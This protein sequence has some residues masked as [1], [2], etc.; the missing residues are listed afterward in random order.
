MAHI[1]SAD[2]IRFPMSAFPTPNLPF[3]ALHLLSLR[4]VPITGRIAT[5]QFVVMSSNLKY[6]YNT[7]K[8]NELGIETFKT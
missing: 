1:S 6:R 4:V 2:I 7:S 5:G 8:L 3:E